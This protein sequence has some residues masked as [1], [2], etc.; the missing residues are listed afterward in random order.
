MFGFNPVAV[1]DH[2]GSARPRLLSFKVA[3]CDLKEFELTRGELK[4]KVLRKSIPI[5]PKLLT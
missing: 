2:I 5:S 3:I 4:C 1:C